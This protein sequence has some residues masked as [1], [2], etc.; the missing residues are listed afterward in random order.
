MLRKLKAC[1]RRVEPPTDGT[2]LVIPPEIAMVFEIAK[3][4][5]IAIVFEVDTAKSAGS[6]LRLPRLYFFVFF[7]AF[8]YR[9][10]CFNQH[11]GLRLTG[12][13]SLAFKNGMESGNGILIFICIRLET[14]QDFNVLGS[15][16][17]S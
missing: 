1:L 13:N 9:M 5:E 14:Y 15:N 7:C 16:T 8:E 12:K 6:T 4:F 11:D 3:V 17:A 10:N 2:P